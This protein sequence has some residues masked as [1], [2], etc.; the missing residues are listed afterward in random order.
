MLRLSPITLIHPVNL[1]THNCLNGS[2][3][4]TFK[5]IVSNKAKTTSSDSYLLSDANE[6]LLLTIPVSAQIAYIF[7]L[8]V[9]AQFYQSARVLNIMIQSSS[10]DN[11]PQTIK[12]L[13]N[14]LSLGFKDVE[15]ADE[16]EVARVLDVPKF[17]ISSSRFHTPTMLQPS[18]RRSWARPTSS[19]PAT[20]LQP[21]KPRK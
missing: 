3:S 1:L 12:F 19:P 6:Q 20:S 21:K 5:S 7:D 14:R 11:A 2:S 15:D 13:A 18:R 17:R 4:H 9:L 8:I 16:P 10:L